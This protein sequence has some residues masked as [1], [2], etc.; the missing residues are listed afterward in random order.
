MTSII[1]TLA[2]ASLGQEVCQCKPL[3]N[4]TLQAND[5]LTYTQKSLTKRNTVVVFLAYNC[6]HNPD[7]VKDLNKFKTLLGKD[8]AM[9]AMVNA[10][11]EQA[12]QYATDLKLK[13]PLIANP[14][15]KTMRAFGVSHSLDLALI[16]SDDKKIGQ[17]WSGYNK[18]TFAEIIKVLPTHGGPKLNVDLSTFTTDRHSG[19][20][21]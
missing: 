10:N 11:V 12:K 14:G 15:A 17:T 8:V 20:G 13:M 3:P 18:D 21:F 2:I 9:V 6:P 5:G 4:F 7:A 1:A 16:C 19:C